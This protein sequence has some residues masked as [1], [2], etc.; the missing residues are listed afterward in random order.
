[1]SRIK[2]LLRR[3]QAP[4][5][6]GDIVKPVELWPRFGK[7]IKAVKEA[8]KDM[9]AHEWGGEDVGITD[10]LGS[11]KQVVNGV[12]LNCTVSGTHSR[13]Y[14]YIEVKGGFVS[15]DGK[16]GKILLAKSSGQKDQEYAAFWLEALGGKGRLEQVVVNGSTFDA[17]DFSRD[18]RGDVVVP[19]GNSDIRLEPEVT[20]E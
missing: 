20:L 17:K 10:L 6:F 2:E 4:S 14:G 11:V 7:V 3:I 9:R 19:I 15:P 12:R 18:N 5:D 13:N 8:E 1:M 16:K